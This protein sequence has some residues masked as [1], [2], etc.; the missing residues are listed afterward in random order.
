MIKVDESRVNV[1]FEIYEGKEARIK[2]INDW[3]NQIIL[4]YPPINIS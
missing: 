1:V 2:K 4:D 3:T